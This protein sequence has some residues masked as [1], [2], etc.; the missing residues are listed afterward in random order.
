[1]KKLASVAIATAL[2]TG[3]S[4]VPEVNWKQDSQI[5]INKV[6]IELKSNLWVNLMPTIG[7]SQEA[8]LHG[9]LSLE[10][11]T[12]LP[13]NLTVEALIIKQGDEQWMLDEDSLETRTHSENQWEV[14]FTWENQVNTE[15]WVELAILLDDAG[16]KRWLVEKYVKINKVY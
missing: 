4:A 7:E 12:Q 5:T 10:S 2:L 1:M 9:S 14:A 8:S 3:C 16:K 6:N 15:K 13:A 11:D